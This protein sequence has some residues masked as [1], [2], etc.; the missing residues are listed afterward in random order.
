MEICI[1]D[2]DRIYQLLMKKMIKSLDA[3]ISVKT[4]YDGEEA[5][6]FYKSKPVCCEILLLDI[7]MPKMDGW[8]FLEKLND[9]DF[10][11]SKIYLATSSIASSDREKAKNYKKIKEYLIKPITKKKISEITQD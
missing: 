1:V 3:T 4:F 10:K 8:E 9:E 6:N 5:Y 11:N 2:D 7:N